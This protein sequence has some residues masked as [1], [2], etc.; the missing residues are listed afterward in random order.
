MSSMDISDNAIVLGRIDY[1]ER[2]RIITVL[3]ENNGKQRAIA[4]G[5]RSSKSKLAGGIELFAENQ[6]MFIKG[7][8]ELLTVTSSRMQTYFKNIVV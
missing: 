3:S 5:V 2:D 6:L 4:K 7:R 1:A 8:G